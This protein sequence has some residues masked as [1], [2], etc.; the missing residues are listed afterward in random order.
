M[1]LFPANRSL[2]QVDL[3]VLRTTWSTQRILGQ[4]RE[5]SE[6]LYQKINDDDDDNDDEQW[7]VTKMWRV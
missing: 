5:Y 1:P 4:P 6:T 2:R 3:Y 7:M